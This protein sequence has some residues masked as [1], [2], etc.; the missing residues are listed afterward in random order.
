VLDSTWLRVLLLIQTRLLLV[1]FGRTRVCVAFVPVRLLLSW[2]LQSFVLIW[3][4]LL[5]I[6]ILS[7]QLL[8]VHCVALAAC[9]STAT[10]LLPIAS[11]RLRSRLQALVL[12]NFKRISFVVHFPLRCFCS[13]DG[14][15]ASSLFTAQCFAASTST[16]TGSDVEW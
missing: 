14:F 1:A 4:L 15:V 5:Q 7:H 8:L 11:E 13:P 2:G 6:S 3:V 16:H 10:V 9:N 12:Y